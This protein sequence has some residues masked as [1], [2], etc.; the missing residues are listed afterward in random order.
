MQPQTA[1]VNGGQIGFIL[2]GTDR[3]DDVPDLIDT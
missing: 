3:I 1:G 2:G